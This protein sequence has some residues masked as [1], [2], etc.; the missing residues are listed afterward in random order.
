MSNIAMQLERT[1]GG[2]VAVASNVIF[3]SILYS[4]GN[5]I[6]N[7]LTGVIT[8]NVPGR[9]VINWWVATQSSASTTGASF[10]LSSS[11]GDLQSGI[12]P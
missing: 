6:Y 9:Y 2:N 12:H 7:T 3:D 5:I 8:F 11:Q 4:S 1:A 10:S